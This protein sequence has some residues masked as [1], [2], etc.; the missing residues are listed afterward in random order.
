MDT[1]SYSF[2]NSQKII[3]PGSE[4]GAGRKAGVIALTELK[5]T[6]HLADCKQ[7]KPF[8]KSEG[9]TSSSNN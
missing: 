5:P 4:V 9:E 6:N 1:F 3:T 2:L 7:K 8:N